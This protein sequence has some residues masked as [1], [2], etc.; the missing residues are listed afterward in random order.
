MEN[1]TVVT[2]NRPRQLVCFADLSEAERRDLDY[3]PEEEHY[4]P[5]IFRYR[6]GVYDVNEFVRIVPRARA[7]AL[8]FV[9]AHTVEEDSPLLAW[10]GIQTDSFFSAI[11]LRYAPDTDYEEVIVGSCYP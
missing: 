10:D 2:N 9:H 11:V 4:T 3:I 1:L 7:G 5:R 6:G 8:S